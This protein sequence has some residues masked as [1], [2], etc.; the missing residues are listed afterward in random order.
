MSYTIDGTFNVFHALNALNIE[1]KQGSTTFFFE[2]I[3]TFELSMSLVSSFSVFLGTF[4]ADFP[5]S[6][7]SIE[8][9]SSLTSNDIYWMFVFLDYRAS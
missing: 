5:I 9:D 8:I 4:F 6:F 3:T 2:L 1:E 7:E